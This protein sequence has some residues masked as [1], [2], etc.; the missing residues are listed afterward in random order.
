MVFLSHG[1]LVIFTVLFSVEILVYFFILGLLL[2]LYILN[3]DLVASFIQF[4]ILCLSD[5]FS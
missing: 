3:D 4:R 5:A 1:L 2:F